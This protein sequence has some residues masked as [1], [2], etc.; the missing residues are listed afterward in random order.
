MH[1]FFNLLAQTTSFLFLVLLSSLV[2]LLVSNFM[3]TIV[4]NAAGYLIKAGPA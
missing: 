2:L 4:S 1:D 3:V